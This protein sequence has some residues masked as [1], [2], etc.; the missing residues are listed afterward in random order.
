MK[1]KLKDICIKTEINPTGL[2]FPFGGKVSLK[3]GDM[4]YVYYYNTKW[5][6]IKCK[7]CKSAVPDMKYFEP[8]MSK[9]WQE[10][11]SFEY[12]VLAH[13]KRWFRWF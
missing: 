4:S 5:K 3:P 2:T 8:D 1:P 6:M 13:R 11:H 12:S 10:F 9:H 7:L